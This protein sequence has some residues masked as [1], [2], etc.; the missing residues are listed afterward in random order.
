MLLQCCNFYAKRTC[1]GSLPQPIVSASGAQQESMTSF[2][3]IVHS[4]N[5]LR[6]MTATISLNCY[7]AA[8]RRNGGGDDE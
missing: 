2:S 7:E 4:M 3:R 1:R 8:K 6:Q 5:S